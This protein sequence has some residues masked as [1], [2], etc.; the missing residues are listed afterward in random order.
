MNSIITTDLNDERFEMA[1]KSKLHG[2][3]CGDQILQVLK[4]TVL[5]QHE[6]SR[7]DTYD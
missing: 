5:H 4:R 1:G 6:K 7:L 2:A 3:S